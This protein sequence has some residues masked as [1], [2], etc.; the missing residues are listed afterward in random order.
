MGGMFPII[1]C[2]RP[3]NPLELPPFPGDVLFSSLD[4]GSGLAEHTVL[5]YESHGDSFEVLA[6]P[7]SQRNNGNGLNPQ[8]RLASDWLLRARAVD[9]SDG[10]ACVYELASASGE[11]HG[12]PAGWFYES[13]FHLYKEP[14]LG[15]STN[16]VGF[17]ASAL[18]IYGVDALEPQ[19]P[20]QFTT[21]LVPPTR[22][23]P[24]PG[25]LA[26]AL[27]GLEPLPYLPDQRAAETFASCTTTHEHAQSGLLP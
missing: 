4:T 11:F 14:V 6:L 2:P 19:Y 21:P 22:T 8:T 12:Q 18:A 3:Q 25:H 7:E 17:V 27:T 23:K 1:A 10:L 16:C 9:E 5:L 20:F 15:M 24:T 13:K 26:R